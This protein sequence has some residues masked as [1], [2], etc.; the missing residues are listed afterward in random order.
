M[1]SELYWLI[2]TTGFSAL[3]FLPYAVIRIDQGV[4][5]VG[6]DIRAVGDRAEVAREP[7][8]EW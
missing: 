3:L 7:V 8:V 1:S 5:G 6:F 4:V 2:L